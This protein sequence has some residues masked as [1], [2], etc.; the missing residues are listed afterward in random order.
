MSRLTASD[1]VTIGRAAL[2]GETS[3]V[4]SDAVLL[5][6]FNQ[7]MQEEC[8]YWRMPELLDS[9]TITTADGTQSYSLDSD[10]MFIAKVIDSTSTAEL[11]EISKVEYD[12]WTLGNTSD[13]GT[14]I[15]WCVA[16]TSSGDLL[17]YPYKIPDGVYSLI[18]TFYHDPT[19]MVLS[20]TPTSMEIHRAWD[21]VVLNKGISK[22]WRYL[23]DLEK[24][25]AFNYYAGDARKA[26]IK[27]S[28]RSS[29]Y[30]PRLGSMVGKTGMI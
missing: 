29:S 17:F 26:A 8:S 1:F 12:R 21:E 11:T 2:G 27:A 6:F 5:R 13:T 20:P 25:Q 3:E 9:Q 18:A 15:F 10:T 7:A 22:G 4:M 16:G 19:E 24:A 14:P 23:G 28:I 30:T